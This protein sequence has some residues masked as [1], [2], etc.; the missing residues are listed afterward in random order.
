M[1]RI[2]DGSDPG[3]PYPVTTT[4]DGHADRQEGKSAMTRKSLF[5]LVT[6]FVAL[7]IV[8][9][10]SVVTA[11]D[12]CGDP[13]GAWC[14]AMTTPD[15]TGSMV[16]DPAVSS[17]THAVSTDNYC[18]VAGGESL[19]RCVQRAASHATGAARVP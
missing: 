8:A 7:F 12:V 6:L 19:D 11:H 4:H 3:I 2:V 9:Q 15:S 10:A 18:D 16:V 1:V 17:P 5:T 13:P 14:A